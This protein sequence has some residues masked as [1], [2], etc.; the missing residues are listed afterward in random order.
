MIGIMRH[1]EYDNIK[2]D[3]LIL[4]VMAYFTDFSLTLSESIVNVIDVLN[5]GLHV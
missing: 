2:E 5:K 3:R 4:S 1:V